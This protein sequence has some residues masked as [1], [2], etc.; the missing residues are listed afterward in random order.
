MGALHKYL[1]TE[2]RAVQIYFVAEARNH[3]ISTYVYN[4]LPNYS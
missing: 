4:T 2:N 3:T 1:C